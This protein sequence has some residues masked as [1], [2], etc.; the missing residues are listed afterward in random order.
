MIEEGKLKFEKS[1]GPA[2]VEYPSRA[3][4][5]MKR[6]E[7]EAPREVV[8][9]KATMPNEKVP[10]TKTGRSGAGCPLATKGSKKRSCEP[11]GEQEKNTF[12]GS[13][14]GLE[15]MSDK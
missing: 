13:T 2:E 4:A 12:Q 8:S 3:K 10:I 6:Q 1:D 14:Q 11:N 15:R 7:K 9:K 5:K